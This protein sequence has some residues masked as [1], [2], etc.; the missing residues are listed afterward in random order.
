M[1]LTKVLP[2]Y[3]MP[4]LWLPFEALPKNASGKIDRP[5]LK[6]AFRQHEASLQESPR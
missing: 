4:F 1:A 3:M 6:E 5:Q 2:T